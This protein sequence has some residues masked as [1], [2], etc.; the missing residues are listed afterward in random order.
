MAIFPLNFNY[1]NRWGLDLACEPKF[2]ASSFGASGTTPLLEYARKIQKT[3]E[4]LVGAS[5]VALPYV[6]LL[7]RYCTSPDLRKIQNGSDR[8]LWNLT[9]SSKGNRAQ[10]SFLQVKLLE[11]IIIKDHFNKLE[12]LHHESRFS[13]WKYIEIFEIN[14]SPIMMVDTNIHLLPLYLH[15]TVLTVS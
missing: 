5:W 4:T 10:K 14:G 7:L 15:L 9:N 1:K 6:I 8:Y 3:T 11:R 13:T 2:A 12:C